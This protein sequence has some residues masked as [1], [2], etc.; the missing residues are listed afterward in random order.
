VF[1]LGWSIITACCSDRFAFAAGDFRSIS[2]L[3]LLSLNVD[4]PMPDTDDIPG[5]REESVVARARLAAP[6]CCRS[7]W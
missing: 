2:S 1:C 3:L 5:G 6:H 7:H 4:Y